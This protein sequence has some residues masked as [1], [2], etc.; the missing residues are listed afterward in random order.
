MKT[1]K[2]CLEIIFTIYDN[3]NTEGYAYGNSFD[4]VYDNVKTLSFFGELKAD[5]SKN[6]SF[7]ING[8]F[9]SYSEKDQNE[10]WNL[11]ALKIGSNLDFNIT[12][13][14]SAGVKCV[15]CWR[16]KRLSSLY[17]FI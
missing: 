1:I 16:T 12:P 3:T 17:T 9:N 6:V 11:P 14:W 5:F 7:G 4:V 10:A 13:K 8:T 15:L 2:L